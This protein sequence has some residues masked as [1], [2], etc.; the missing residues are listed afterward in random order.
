MAE[1]AKAAFRIEEPKLK[2]FLSYSRRDLDFAEDLLEA[3]KTCG[4]EPYLDKHDIAPGEAW[5]DRLDRLI[6]SADTIVY[7][8]S[9]ESVSSQRCGWEI[10]KAEKLGKRLLPVVWR[11]VTEAQTPERLR[12]LNYIFFEGA[13]RTFAKGLSELARALNTDVAWIREHSR[14]GEMAMRWEARERT[15]SM[16]LRGIDIANAKTWLGRRPKEAPEATEL[17][18]QFITAS[19]QNAIVEADTDRIKEERAGRLKR[20]IM[21]VSFAT[22]VTTGLAAF[23]L[24]QTRNAMQQTLIAERQTQLSLVEKANALIANQVAIAERNKGLATQSR[25]LADVGQQR[26]RDG[27]AVTGLLLGLEALPDETSPDRANRE[28]PVEPGAR[29]SVIHAFSQMRETAVYA[30]EVPEDAEILQGQ[31]RLAYASKNDTLYVLDVPTGKIVRTI[32]AKE[33]AF[34]TDSGLR[35][36]A[37]PNDAAVRLLDLENGPLD[38]KAGKILGD[39]IGHTAAVSFANFSVDTNRVVTGSVDKSAIVWNVRTAKSI[40][41]LSGH[42]SEVTWAAFSDDAN[43]VATSDE[44]SVRIWDVAT[45]SL[46]HL[47]S[48]GP[49]ISKAALSPSGSLAVLLEGRR[50]HVFDANKIKDKEKEQAVFEAKVNIARVVISTDDKHMAVALEDGSVEIVNT[51][52]G[53][54]LMPLRA[55]VGRIIDLGFIKSGAELMTLGTDK[56]VRFWDVTP[57]RTSAIDNSIAPQILPVTQSPARAVSISSDGTRVATA[58]GHAV[59][60]WDAAKGA[61]LQTWDATDTKNYVTTVAFSPDGQKL[62]TAASDAKAIVWDIATAQQKTVLSGHSGVIHMARFS[63]DGRFIVT[64]SGEETTQT[65]GRVQQSPREGIAFFDNTVRVWDAASGQ[66]QSTFFGFSKAVRSAVFSKDARSILSASQ[67]GTVRILDVLSHQEVQRIIAADRNV[68]SAA[69]NADE[70]RIV[71]VAGS[72][73]KVFD[74]KTGQQLALL[75][76]HQSPVRAAAFSPDGAL[77]ATSSGQNNDNTQADASIR[78]WNGTTNDP[79]GVLEGPQLSTDAIAFSADGTRLVSGSRDGKTRIWSLELARTA[80][81]DLIRRARVAAPRCLTRSQRAKLFLADDPP[82]WCTALRK[83]PYLGIEGPARPAP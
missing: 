39:L 44:R 33:A 67:D 64:A 35:V 53:R 52:T 76:G 17:Q 31:R 81:T 57:D 75:R 48:V 29:E 16:M 42:H 34:T 50:A 21:A 82:A 79:A 6:Q 80:D 2:V 9:P 37:I 59:N 18:R 19:E 7:V 72:A 43:I 26:A 66:V 51:T 45:S 11:A 55:H 49:V 69:F 68:T 4:F 23:A 71:V 58:T 20:V 46:K 65:T 36:A 61:T 62:L 73:A 32:K 8:I 25:Y 41:T 1:P 77:I 3:L 78:L 40:A 70:T 27:D 13:G 12:R 22:I 63:H 54:T 24:Y 5:E 28:R 15:P 56:T 10:E 38:S 14:L 47:W 60:V 83:W 30:V 74:V